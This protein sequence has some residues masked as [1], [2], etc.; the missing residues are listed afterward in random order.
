[1]KSA[2]GLQIFSLWTDILIRTVPRERLPVPF[3]PI[4]LGEAPLQHASRPPRTSPNSPVYM[5]EKLNKNPAGRK[6][7]S[8]A[9]VAG[10]GVAKPEPKLKWKQHLALSEKQSA[11]SETSDNGES[12]RAG[13]GGSLRDLAH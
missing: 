11:A 4:N 5:T 8:P 2:C 3:L 7:S 1:M 12:E 9:K 13:G 10:L 6:N